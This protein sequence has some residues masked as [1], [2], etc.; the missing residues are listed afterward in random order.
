MIHLTKFTELP[1]RY[2]EALK[3]TPD[4]T[5]SHERIGSAIANLKK[6]LQESDKIIAVVK[7]ET[8]NLDLS[9]DEIEPS[10]GQQ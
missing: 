10:A 4:D 3:I 1:L 8:I 5:Y 2:Q 7:D 9:L 6:M